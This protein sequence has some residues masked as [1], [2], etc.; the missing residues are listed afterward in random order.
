MQAILGILF[1]VFLAW[2][3]SERKKE[4]L[5]I[6]TGLA[7]LAQIV[8]AFILIKIPVVADALAQLNYIVRAVEAA[9]MEGAKFVFDFLGGG[10]SPFELTGDSAP[11][12]FAFRVL[13]TV[14]VFS[15]IVALLWHWRVLSTIVLGFAWLLRRTLKLSGAVGVAAAASLFLSMVETPMLI[16]AYL[17]NLTRSE[18][19]VVMTCGM[20][21]IA[22]SVMVIFASFLSDIIDG[23][24]GQLI[25]ASVINVIGAV[26]I[27]RLM[28]PPQPGVDQDA[29]LSTMLVYDSSVDAVTKGTTDGLRL[30]ANIGAMLI[31]LISLV[32]LVN[33]ILGSLPFFEQPITLQKITGYI[34]MPLAWLMGVPWIDALGAGE[35]MGTKLIINEFAAYRAFS[36]EGVGLGEHTRLILTY[37][38]CGFTN[39][40]SLGILVSGVST[41]CPERKE[42]ILRLGPRTLVSGTLV[43]FLTGSVVGLV[44][45]TFGA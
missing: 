7:I 21:T 41:L 26:V 8:I 44:G 18:L 5:L 23:A 2:C 10:E 14:L 43:S 31:V 42:E 33:V 34:F 13:P 37:S 38:L 30:V 16:R 17:R 35:L 19:F 1:F 15:V 45:V 12:I 32:A 4:A 22:G 27:A 40:G 24:L 6:P 25:T 3:F 29:D 20:S 11:Y 39:V 28:V 9:S 36:V